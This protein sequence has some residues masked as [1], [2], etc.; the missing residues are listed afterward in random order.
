MERSRSEMS[1]NPAS[2]CRYRRVGRVADPFHYRQYSH[3]IQASGYRRRGHRGRRCRQIGR[4]PKDTG[5]G[6]NNSDEA[7]VF[8]FAVRVR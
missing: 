2:R 4:G 1:W 3:Y 8:S 6:D 5:R 7:F